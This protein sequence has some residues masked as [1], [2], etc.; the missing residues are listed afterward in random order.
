MKQNVVRGYLDLPW[1]QVHY[2]SVSP[3]D[4]ARAPAPTMLMLHQSP[5][6]SRNYDLL[7]PHLAGFCRPY[8]LDTPGY[9]A[10]SPAPEDWEVADYADAVWACADEIGAER[11]VLFGRATG[12][13]FAVEAALSRPERVQGLILHGMPVYTAEERQD[14]LAGFAPPIDET[15]D[16]AHLQTIW[17][18]IK[19]EYPWI[20]PK[21]AT[22]FVRDYLAA[23]PD[24]ASS[25]RAIWRYDLPARVRD[26]LKVP[27]LLLGG[28]RD[29]IAFMHERTVELLP[30]ARS[31]F[32]EKA[33]DFVAEQDPALFAN[34]LKDFIVAG[35]R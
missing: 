25:Y 6:S 16:G 34:H 20:D 14:R 3:P 8:A 7:L 33:T 15:A 35:I 23:G 24:F 29:R 30:D 12:T 32:L 28:A 13:V 2:R 9:G 31:V 5:L 1:G 4:A 17:N 10:S 22:A 18:R 27:T 11:I 26:N 19:G 21:L